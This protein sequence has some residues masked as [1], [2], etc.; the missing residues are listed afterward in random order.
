MYMFAKFE[1]ILEMTLQDIEETK[2]YGRTQAYTE[3]QCETLYPTQAS[4][5]G[6]KK[7]VAYKLIQ[8]DND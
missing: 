8:Q 4:L 5:R 3:G 1:E 2:H 7:S 6:H